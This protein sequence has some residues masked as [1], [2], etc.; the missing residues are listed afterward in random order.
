MNIERHLILV[1]DKD[2]TDDIAYCKYL[3][4][5]WRVTYYNNNKEYPY[6]YQN[7]AWHRDPKVI[8]H[9]TYIVYESN[10]P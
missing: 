1:N 8:N 4:G 10:Q 7:V 2:R 6:S 3:D 5:K 9:E